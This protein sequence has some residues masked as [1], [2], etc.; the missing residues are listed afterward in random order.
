MTLL[1]ALLLALAADPGH[2]LTAAAPVAAAPAADPPTIDQLV[3]RVAELRQQKAELA[4][5]EQAA[6]ADLR[7]RLKALNDLLKDLDVGPVVPPSPP[8]P[9]PPADPLA[10]ALK[11][12]YLADTGAAKA[13]QLADLA[14]LYRQAADLAG[15]ES[16]ATATQL[17]ERI[18]AASVVLKIDGLL[19]CR[20]LIAAECVRVLGTDPDA[21]LDAATRVAAKTLFLR[22]HEALKG[23]GG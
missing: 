4:K 20:K 10:V 21:R 7:E 8:N 14:E 11:A 5:Q 16:V 12:A 23:A 22:I 9:K 17:M 13:N 15:Q 6:L 18:R 2:R 19:P 1:A 3:K